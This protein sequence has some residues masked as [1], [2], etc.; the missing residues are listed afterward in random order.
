MR[1]FLLGAIGLVTLYNVVQADNTGLLALANLPSRFA[2]YL[3]SPDVPLVPDLRTDQ[4]VPGIPWGGG[5][6]PA[7]SVTPSSP[8][9]TDQPRTVLA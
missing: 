9:S 4:P 2:H 1:G 6:Q 3:V 7:A 5:V 8:S